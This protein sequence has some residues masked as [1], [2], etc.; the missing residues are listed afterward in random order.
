MTKGD[1]VLNF[2]NELWNT[3]ADFTTTMTKAIQQYR[4]TMIRLFK[5]LTLFAMYLSSV[6]AIA[7]DKEKNIKLQHLSIKNRSFSL[8]LDSVVLHE[9]KCHYYDSKLLFSIY[10]KEYEG[11]VLLPIGSLKDINNLLSARSYGYFYYQNH[12]FIVEG[13]IY[14]SEE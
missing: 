2:I 5:I 7:Q 11:K 8:I 14:R 12:L 1:A 9:K 13:E 4:M 3:T 6:N 10:I